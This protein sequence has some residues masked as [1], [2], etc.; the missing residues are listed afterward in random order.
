LGLE[1]SARVVPVDNV[2]LPMQGTPLGLT[3]GLPYRFA[4]FVKTKSG[5]PGTA[6]LTC[7]LRVRFENR[8]GTSSPY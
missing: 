6:V 1:T 4:V 5:P 2:V 7:G 8:N 3:M